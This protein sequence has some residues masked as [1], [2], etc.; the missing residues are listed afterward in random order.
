M[1]HMVYTENTTFDRTQQMATL[2]AQNRDV[3]KALCKSIYTQKAYK[4]IKQAFI[5]GKMEVPPWNGQNDTGGFK[6]GLRALNVILTPY[7]VYTYMTRSVRI[8]IILFKAHNMLS[9]SMNNCCYFRFV[10]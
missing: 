1:K 6:A 2:T 10:C 5:Q 7:F 4:N 8:I 9:F 3:E